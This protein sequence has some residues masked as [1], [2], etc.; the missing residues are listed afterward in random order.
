MSN[1]KNTSF[2]HEGSVVKLKTP[3]KPSKPSDLTT[4]LL[5]TVIIDSVMDVLPIDPDDFAT[6]AQSRREWPGFTHGVVAQ[7]T[8]TDYN[9]DETHVS[10][11]LYDPIRL[12]IYCGENSV[13]PV[14]V[15]Y[16]ADELIPLHPHDVT[17][18][19]VVTEEMRQEE[20]RD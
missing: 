8:T 6:Q 4:M 19:N 12:L 5:E 10:L 2:W 16:R 17:G 11:F 3:Y 15:D 18:Y 7:I 9:A 13:V 1:K 20:N 14:Y